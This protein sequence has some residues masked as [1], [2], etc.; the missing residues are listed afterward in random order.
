MHRLL[1]EYKKEDE[2]K[3]TYYKQSK[4]QKDKNY[5]QSRNQAINQST[6]CSLQ[7]KPE[8]RLYNEI[9]GTKHV[10]TETERWIIGRDGEAVIQRKYH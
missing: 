8:P 10:E 9:E 4:W 6:C 5:N 1:T 2:S 7:S 3:D